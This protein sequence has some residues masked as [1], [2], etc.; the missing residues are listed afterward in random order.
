MERIIDYRI[1]SKRQTSD[2]Q[3]EVQDLIKNHGWEPVGS[4]VVVTKDSFEQYSGNQHRA[5]QY[6]NVYSQTLVKRS[7]HVDLG[8]G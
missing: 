6:T 5:T 1:V 8:P 4:H 3:M 7:T 2:L